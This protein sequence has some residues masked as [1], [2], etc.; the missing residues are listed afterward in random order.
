MIAC[1]L[2]MLNYLMSLSESEKSDASAGITRHS[3]K[4]GMLIKRTC[5]FIHWYVLL[6]RCYKNI[7]PSIQFTF[8]RFQQ[9]KPALDSMLKVLIIDEREGIVM[10]VVK[11][12]L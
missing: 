10:V 12:G 5:I 11:T 9:I 2:Q 3:V 4:R 1:S 6:F 7:E 8:S